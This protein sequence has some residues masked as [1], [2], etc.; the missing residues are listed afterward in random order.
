MCSVKAAVAEVHEKRPLP[1]RAAESK[2]GWGSNLQSHCLV[3]NTDVSEICCPGGNVS[4]WNSQSFSTYIKMNSI[5]IIDT[6]LL[7]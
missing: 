1:Q 5:S 2:R 6:I 3:L 4:S 7:N